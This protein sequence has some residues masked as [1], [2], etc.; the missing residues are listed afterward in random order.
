M[1]WM[2][3]KHTLP[4]RTPIIPKHHSS[5]EAPTHKA[6]RHLTFEAEAT[7]VPAPRAACG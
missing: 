6:K 5:V 1:A 3:S 4:S 7:Q 2:D